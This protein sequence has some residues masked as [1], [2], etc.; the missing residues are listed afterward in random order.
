MADRDG[1]LDDFRR[2]MQQA[3]ADYDENRIAARLGEHLTQDDKRFRSRIAELTA[4]GFNVEFKLKN[5]E[6]WNV[7]CV[8]PDAYH[9]YQAHVRD[10]GVVVWP[11]IW[12][13]DDLSLVETIGQI[14]DVVLNESDA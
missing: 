4:W 10:D 3:G 11:N 9:F 7:E 13:A 12:V 5:G 14:R 2:E 8:G 1:F 6:W